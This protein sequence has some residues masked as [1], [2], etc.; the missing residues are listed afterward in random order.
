MGNVHCPESRV[1]KFHRRITERPEEKRRKSRRYL[2]C[3]YVATYS[4]VGFGVMLFIRS[5]EYERC[6]LVYYCNV[7]A[8]ALMRSVFCYALPVM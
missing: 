5:H 8:A 3:M 2:L 4:I 1:L 6:L 7:I